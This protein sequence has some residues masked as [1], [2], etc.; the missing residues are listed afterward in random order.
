MATCLI[1]L[2]PQIHLK[3]QIGLLMRVPLINS[4]E[5]PFFVQTPGSGLYLDSNA[6]WPFRMFSRRKFMSKLEKISEIV[7]STYDPEETFPFDGSIFPLETYLLRSKL[8]S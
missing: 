2:N 5:H 7:F 4:S 3:F 1:G 8:K 6:S